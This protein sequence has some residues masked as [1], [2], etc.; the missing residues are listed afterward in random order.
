VRARDEDHGE[1]EGIGDA[2][3]ER[4]APARRQNHPRL[5]LPLS[6]APNVGNAANEVP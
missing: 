3:P 2:L 4:G 6:V 5:L 1:K